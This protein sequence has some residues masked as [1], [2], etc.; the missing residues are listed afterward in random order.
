MYKH[1]KWLLY[2]F[3]YLISG[4]CDTCELTISTSVK[5]KNDTIWIALQENITITV[6]FPQ[7]GHSAFTFAVNSEVFSASNIN[8]N[9]T[10]T[11][12]KDTPNL[13]QTLEVQYHC[14][15]VEPGNY[16]IKAHVYYCGNDYFTQTFT[17][18]VENGN[19]KY[20]VISLIY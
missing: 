1:F 16:S 8:P 2:L 5:S 20:V 17:V 13:T 7:R 12:V 19:S 11:S 18:K 14:I 10:C 4:S 9:F 6:N 3:I 15:A